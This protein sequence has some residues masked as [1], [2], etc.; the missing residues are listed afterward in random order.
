MKPTARLVNCA[1]GGIINE[2]DLAHALEENVIQGAAIDVYAKE[3]LSENSL[4]VL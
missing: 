1:R 3:P 2:N 4:Y